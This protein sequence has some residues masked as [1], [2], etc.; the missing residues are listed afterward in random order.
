[1][2]ALEEDAR[3]AAAAREALAGT[4]VEVVEGA[5]AKGHAAGAPYDFVLIDGA[6]ERVPEAIID[7]VADGGKIALALL[8]QGVTRL[9]VGHVVAGAFGTRAYSDAAAAALP[10]F[11][12][13]RAFSF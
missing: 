7:Q 9:S 5:L 4:G 3:L 1:V 10:G 12:K 13:P 8:D 6:V 2:V 11:E